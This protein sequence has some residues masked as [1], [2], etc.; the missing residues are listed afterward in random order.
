MIKYTNYKNFKKDFISYYIISFVGITF[1]ANILHGGAP[2][3]Y[4][5]PIFTV[6]PLVLAIYLEK[7]KFW[8]ILM[9]LIFLINFNFYFRFESPNDFISIDKQNNMAKQIVSEA[10][11]RQINLKRI[12]PHDYYPENYAQNYKYL[13]LYNGGKLNDN[14]DYV[15]TINE[16]ESFNIK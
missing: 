16:Y 10:R 9:F 14:S 2:V 5:L 7:L 15:I 4:F 6:T 8:P 12:G 1:V 11:D 3:H 13:I